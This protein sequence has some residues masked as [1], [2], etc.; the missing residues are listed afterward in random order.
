MSSK[1]IVVDYGSGNLRSAEKAL[2][3]AAHEA[4][5]D[6]DI[7]VSSDPDAL[8]KADKI[9]LP[10]VGAFADCMA[11]LTAID[12]L[13]EALV[14][15]VQHKATPFLGICVGMQLMAEVG[16]EHGRHQGLGWVKGEIAPLEPKDAALK[17]PHMGWNELNIKKPHALLQDVTSGTH[18]YFVHSY[19]LRGNDEDVIATSDYGGEFA[20]MVVRDNFAGVQFHPEKSQKTGLAI[21]RNFLNWQ[22]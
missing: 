10:G 9:V 21:L 12:G 17:I 3:R 8:S 16:L 2:V 11:G 18:V 7:A 13:K 20:A 22:P 5:L 19:A 1:S 4:G 15:A 6:Y 14:E